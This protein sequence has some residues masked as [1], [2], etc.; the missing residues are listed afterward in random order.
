MN[1]RLMATLSLLAMAL[2]SLGG[3]AA[4]AAGGRMVSGV[5]N[6]MSGYGEKNDNGLAKAGGSLYQNIGATIQGIAGKKPA[7][8]ATAANAPVSTGN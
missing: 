4:V 7:A 1:I 3:C 5:G 8:P 2:F 6:S